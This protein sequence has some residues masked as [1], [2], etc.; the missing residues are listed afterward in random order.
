MLAAL[1]WRVPA[2][3]RQVDASADQRATDFAT[4]ALAAAPD[5]AIILT[6]S[7]RDIFAL[8]YAHYALGQRR[9]LAVIAEPLL[10]FGW[11]RAN[12]RLTYP[13]LQLPEQPNGT[14]PVALIAANPNRGPLCQSNPD[15]AIA[16]N[17]DGSATRSSRFPSRV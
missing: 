14:W 10:E 8:W 9:D 13:T 3:A 7:D 17:C 5:Q 2:T 16:L 4:R 6:H 11:Y 15:G 1:L 12:L